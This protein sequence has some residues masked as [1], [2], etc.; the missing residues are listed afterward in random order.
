M[1]ASHTIRKGG[2]SGRP[3]LLS[4]I[5]MVV[6]AGKLVG[7]PTWS[8]WA[9]NRVMEKAEGSLGPS[10]GK[11]DR[12]EPV[13]QDGESFVRRSTPKLSLPLAAP[14]TRSKRTSCR[15][16]TPYAMRFRRLRST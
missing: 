14:E 12:A 7:G 5:D 10:L 9:A 6:A 15:S 16:K 11:S 4:L 1:V 2:Q 13:L 3:H 8:T